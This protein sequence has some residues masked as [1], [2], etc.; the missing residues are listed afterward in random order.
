MLP[1]P[2]MNA[3]TISLMLPIEARGQR[4][5]A[6]IATALP[7]HSRARIQQWIKDGHLLLNGKTC[8][9]KDKA[10]GGEQ[11]TIQAPILTQHSY[12]AEDIPLDIIHSDTDIIIL[13]KP[14]GL[15]AHPAAGNYNGTLLNALLHHFPEL[16]Q[17]P[18]AGIIHRLDKDTS[19][20]LVLARNLTAHT[21][22]TAALQAR[23]LK[24]EYLALV[25]GYMT[26]GGSIETDIGRHPHSRTKMAVVTNGKNARTHYRIAERLFEHTLL[27]VTLDTGRTHQIRVHMAYLHH[28][29]VGD[30]TYGKLRL[31]KGASENIKQ[32]LANFK[33]QALHAHKLGFIH[34]SCNNYCEFTAAIPDDMQN[35]LATLRSDHA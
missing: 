18:R 3:I 10:N 27:R 9:P 24:R 2:T 26:A 33:R 6:A 12:A 34:P 19:G 16:T 25:Q 21:K 17:I 14:I 32:R 20:I 13:N 30:Q 4:L 5:D 11:I 29:I 7:E 22:L 8:K 31:P 28:P 35:L 1:L 15:V 23:Q